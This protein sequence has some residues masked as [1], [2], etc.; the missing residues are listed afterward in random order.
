[1]LWLGGCTES[2]PLLLLP[3]SGKLT[4]PFVGGSFFIPLL[5]R[6][7][8]GGHSRGAVMENEAGATF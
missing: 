2:G 6:E 7:S 3:Q 4:C 5:N 1:M 8:S